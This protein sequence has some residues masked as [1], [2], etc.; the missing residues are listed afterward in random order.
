MVEA[1]MLS[2]KRIIIVAGIIIT[3]MILVPPT[4]V[5]VGKTP[6]YV[7]YELIFNIGAQEHIR[8]GVL[9]MQVLAVVVATSVALY[10]KSTGAR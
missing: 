1:M 6:T 9:A 5:Y 10:L 2:K 4:V 8:F 7:D 3:W